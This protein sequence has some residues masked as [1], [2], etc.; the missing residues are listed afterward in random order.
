MNTERENTTARRRKSGR[1]SAGGVFLIVVL[2][3]IFAVTLIVLVDGRHPRF[4]M[5]GGE[6]VDTA[7][8]KPYEEPGVRAVL[9]GRLSGEG[10]EALPLQTKGTVDTATLGRYELTYSVGYGL[11][12]YSCTRTVTVKDMSPPVITLKHSDGNRAGWLRGYEEE[13]Y[14]A[15]DDVDG[16]I[17]DRVTREETADQIR[18]TVK[19][20]AG[21]ESSAVRTIEFA[22]TRPELFLAG[23]TEMHVAA[24]L[25][26]QDPGCAA[27]DSLGNDMTRYVVRE[28]EVIPY[29]AGT[30]ELSYSITNAAGETVQTKRSVFVEENELPETVAPD[31]KT[32]YLTFNGGPG[33]FTEQLLDVLKKYEVQATFFVSCAEPEFAACIGRAYR[34]GHAV[35]VLSAG[36]DYRAVYESERTFFEDFKKVEDLILEQTGSY[37]SI[38]RFPRGSSNTVSV[39]NK[40]IMTRLAADIN[41]M[42]YQYFDWDV[43]SGDAG[44]TTK[45]DVVASNVINGI[46]GRDTAVVLQ[47]DTKDFSVEA[48]ETIIKWGMRRGYSFRALDV[49]S[50]PAHHRIVN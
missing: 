45:T 40:G 8:G 10:K 36:Q 33:P 18:Y 19:D 14:T 29:E 50:P 2:Y 27:R 12:E 43:D 38:C 25:S 31:K 34:E 26:F 3:V 42:G 23:A 11:R 6:Q 28:G 24:G 1:S 41:G 13:G 15:V 35:G 17:T 22:N 7:Y 39:F 30:Y 49:T 46:Y 20:L 48:V 47:H 32:I 44:K 4:Y 37:S 9:T 16:D 21:N 5:T